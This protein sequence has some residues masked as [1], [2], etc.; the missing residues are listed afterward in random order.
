MDVRCTQG[1]IG[2]KNVAG[3]D[4]HSLGFGTGRSEAVRPNLAR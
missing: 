4:C 1:I 2:N 3:C